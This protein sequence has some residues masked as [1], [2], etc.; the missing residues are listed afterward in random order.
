MQCLA[1]ATT[2]AVP[3]TSSPAVIERMPVDGVV[4]ASARRRRRKSSTTNKVPHRPSAPVTA[5]AGADVVAT[6]CVDISILTSVTDRGRGGSAPHRDNR[7][8]SNWLPS[9][10]RTWRQRRRG[11]AGRGMGALREERARKHRRPGGCRESTRQM[12]GSGAESTCDGT[13]AARDCHS[14]LCDTEL[15]CTHA[16][17][18]LFVSQR[19][20]G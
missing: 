17:T 2:A 13:A 8:R 20:A 12:E 3:K 6:V 10:D 5:V 9:S 19:W 15:C 16:A 14:V 1:T 18:R 4:D 11:G 7:H